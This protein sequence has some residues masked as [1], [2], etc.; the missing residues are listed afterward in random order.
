MQTIYLQ[1]I[2]YK[3]VPGVM[4]K[5]IF[6]VSAFLLISMILPIIAAA[7]E[8]NDFLTTTTADSI[9]GADITLNKAQRQPSG[10]TRFLNS[11][12]GGM[13]K[14][15]SQTALLQKKKDKLAYFTELREAG[16]SA[17]EAMKRVNGSKIS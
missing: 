1:T 7:S 5:F 8:N 3:M 2:V 14:N 12:L 13:L 17:E 4:K 9:D 16:Y 11:F 15:N 6:L 10:G